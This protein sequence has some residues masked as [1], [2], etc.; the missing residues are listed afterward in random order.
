MPCS[1]IAVIVIAAGQSSRF[2]GDK[3]VATLNNGKILISSTL[4]AIK[5]H[6]PNSRV[7]IKSKDL[8]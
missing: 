3:R 8:V 6:F 5:V 4:L 2:G 7:V 1:D